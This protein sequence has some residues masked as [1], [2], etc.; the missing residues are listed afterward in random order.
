MADSP[1]VLGLDSGGTRI[2]T[3]VFAPDGE[4]VASATVSGGGQNGARASFERGIRSARDLLPA[5]AALI[6]AIALAV[7]AISPRGGHGDGHH[8]NLSSVMHSEG[9]PT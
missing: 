6:G 5:A 7:D 3:A 4:R 9:I 2:A 1:V 8:V